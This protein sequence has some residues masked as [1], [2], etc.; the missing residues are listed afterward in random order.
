[1]R[2]SLV[3][4][5]IFSMAL[6]VQGCALLRSPAPILSDKKQSIP[7][8]YHTVQKRE[9]LWKICRAYG[10][11][12]Q[13]V[14]EIN[15]IKD[16]SLIKAG[17]RIFI[18]GAVKPIHLS[19]TKPSADKTP[20][21]KIISRPGLFSWPVRGKII[22]EYGIYGGIKHDGI[23]I[24]APEGAPV[25]AA[26][27]GTV[28]FSG[29]LDGY[30][31]TIIIEHK[32]NYATVYANNQANLVTKGQTVAKGQKIAEVGGSPSSKPQPYLHFQIRCDNKP[33]NPRFYLPKA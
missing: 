29:V 26:K 17:D 8:A 25:K 16:T 9:S 23:N 20:P 1:M 6:L 22:E 21:E 28:A 33:R 19:E 5:L 3:L 24:K 2:R 15:N 31:N 32:D 18:P 11:S 7:G 30:G 13:D 12:M 14:A 27:E 4:L 10:S